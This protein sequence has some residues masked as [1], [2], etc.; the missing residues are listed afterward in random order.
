MADSAGTPADSGAT[1]TVCRPDLTKDLPLSV[2]I[3]IALLL[4]TLGGALFALFGLP[5]PWMLGAMIVT[6]IAVLS[7]V[8]LAAPNAARPVMV[9]VIGVMLG[10]S[11][12]PEIFSRAGD[13]LISLS[14]LALYVAI[15]A[16]MVVPFYRRLGRM[17]GPTAFFA[18]MPGGINDMTE[19][20]ES[21]GGDGRRI[22]LAHAAR[23]VVT[24][25]TVAFFFR[26]ALGHDVSGVS[27]ADQGD[28][29]G[30]SDV[31]LLIGSGI[32]GCAL[33]MLL[34]LPAPTLLGPMI[35]SALVH[36]LGWT[37]SA[38]P[39]WL[40]V[41]S[42]VFLGT[43]MGCRFLGCPKGLVVRAL[44]L[45][46]GA[47]VMTLALSILF[48]LAFH[49]LFGQAVEQVLL[50]YAPGGLTEMSLVALAMDADVAYITLHHIVRITML[51]AVAPTILKAMARGLQR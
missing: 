37:N 39:A 47:T 25:G 31:G 43:I 2:R 48:A 21:M 51:I 7:G 13:W 42:Q 20:G 10:S 33:G 30:L 44:L 11:F 4:G 23:I 45:G 3:A 6:L 15:A 16:V 17:D 40:I 41:V 5:L 9:T 1:T 35:L 26:F 24:V 36:M 49:G 14:F 19:I 28:P 32:F 8:P 50:A 34:K 38:P 18:A 29:L 22:V 46:T 27:L 12:R